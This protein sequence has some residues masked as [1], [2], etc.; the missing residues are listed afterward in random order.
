MKTKKGKERKKEKKKKKSKKEGKKN[1]E[2]INERKY[3][4]DLK[5][6]DGIQIHNVCSI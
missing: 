1:E 5:D 3:L 2:R 4:G 6:V